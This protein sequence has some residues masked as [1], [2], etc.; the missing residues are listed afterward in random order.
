[1]RLCSFALASIVRL[2]TFALAFGFWPPC[3]CSPARLWPCPWLLLFVFRLLLV[4]LLAESFANQVFTTT[5]NAKFAE[6]TY[7]TALQSNFGTFDANGNL[8]SYLNGTKYT[9]DNDGS[10][11]LSATEFINLKFDK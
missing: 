4:W 9:G 11:N 3:S 1:M 2:C 10:T 8:T 6:S 7:V 5:T